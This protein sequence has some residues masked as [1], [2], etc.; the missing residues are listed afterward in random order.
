VVA[1]R[2][3]KVGISLLVLLLVGFGLL[4]VADRVGAATAENVLAD[5]AAK[6]MKARNITSAQ[7]P[8]VSVGG[9]PFLTQ[10]LA[11]K[12]DKVTIKVNQPATSTVKLETLT[13]VAAP[14]HAPLKVLTSHE[15][16]VTADLVT[17]TA[18]MNWAEV[19]K[20]LE[21]AGAPGIDPSQVQLSVVDDQIRL[22][23]P[24][25]AN[26]IQGAVTAT[27]TLAVADGKV[28]VK[29]TNVAAE[30]AN[31]PAYITRWV[32]SAA[33]NITVQLKIPQMPYKLTVK[34]VETTSTGIMA[35]ASADHVRLAGG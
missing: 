9:F 6:E 4:I 11:G 3:R 34:K 32:N 8:E 31:V 5:Q 26:G 14:V 10:V 1:S 28:R 21:V 15:G 12:Y 20:L 17:G 25:A 7:K 19:T 18:T 27:G 23:I 24:V 35:I 30:G 13:L 29:L 2:R 22:R 33:R 16:E